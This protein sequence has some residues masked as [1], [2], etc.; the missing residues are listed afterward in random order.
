MVTCSQSIS[1]RIALTGVKVKSTKSKKWLELENSDNSLPDKL[2][3]S[4]S[5]DYFGK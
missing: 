1:E 2:N 5:K 4:T 3:F